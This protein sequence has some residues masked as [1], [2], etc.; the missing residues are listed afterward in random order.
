MSTLLRKEV[1]EGK[2]S[3]SKD[4]PNCIH[5]MGE[6][7]KSD[8]RL[9]PITDYS[10]PESTSI[11]SFMHTTCEE[12][13]YHSVNDVTKILSR[14][15]YMSVLDI[16]SSY[17]L[18]PIYPT[19]SK[20]QGFKWDFDDGNGEIVLVENRLCFGLKCAPYIFNLLSK[21]V[22]AMA[23]SRGVANM[24][25]YLDNFIIVGNTWEE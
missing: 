12:F 4:K 9:R 14:G 1:S 7:T 15:D 10:L 20:F 3:I 13:K 6:V 2:V 24:V 23:K 22:V 21:L 8:G 17:R 25:N 16:A 11:N 19:H 18:V 5:V